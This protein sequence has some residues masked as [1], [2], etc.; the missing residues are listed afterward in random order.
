MPRPDTIS[1][2]YTNK[3]KGV[4]QDYKKVIN[5]YHK[6]AEQGS[7]EAQYNLGLMYSDG[8]GVPQDYAHAHM[9]LNL[10]ASQGHENAT[11]SREIVEDN[12]MT[13]EQIAEGKRL[14]KEWIERR[15]KRITTTEPTILS[16]LS[17]NRVKVTRRID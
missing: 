8:L 17:F 12:L 14:A 5:W 11:K 3:G 13:R 1:A 7:A 15:S 16:G 6:A 9:W 2:L 4:P 10:A